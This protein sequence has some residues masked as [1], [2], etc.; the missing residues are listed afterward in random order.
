MDNNTKFELQLVVIGVLL[1]LYFE[2]L[3][4]FLTNMLDLVQLPVTFN[5]IRYVLYMLGLLWFICL[6]LGTYSL[7]NGNDA[8][9]EYSLKYHKALYKFNNQATI[10]LFAF[11]I[12]S[13][14]DLVLFMYLPFNLFVIASIL[15]FGLII[16]GITRII[17]GMFYVK[18]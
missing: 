1:P 13:Y 17:W 9:K 10:V 14:F 4:N 12:V 3:P 7:I 8:L 16:W 5:V 11:L 6:M 18:K 15:L 2:V